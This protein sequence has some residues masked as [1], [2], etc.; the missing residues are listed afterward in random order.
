MTTDSIM[1]INRLGFAG[2]EMQDFAYLRALAYAD[3]AAASPG[4]VVHVA[5]KTARDGGGREAFIRAWTEQGR[6]AARMADDAWVA[7]RRLT[8]RTFLHRAYNYLRAAEFYCDRGRAEEFTAL[9]DRSV[10]CFDRALP[11]LDTPAERIAIPYE[12]GVALPGYFFAADDSGTRR[13]T[14]II[15]GGGDGHGEELYFLAGVPHALAR[16]LNVV[17]FHGPGQRGLLHHHPDQ[18]FRADSEVPFAAV[19][20]FVTDRSDVQ[21]DRIALYGLSFG[22]YLAPRAAAYDRRVAALVANAPITDFHAVILDAL[23]SAL[24]DPV[25]ADA[26]AEFWNGLHQQLGSADWALHATVENYML[27]TTG[28]RTLSDF[29]RIARDFTLDGL[30]P[31]ISCPTL[32]LSSDGENAVARRQAR[33]FHERLDVPTKAIHRLAAEHGADSHCG[34]SNIAL[35]SALVYDWLTD[36]LGR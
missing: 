1:A 27:W 6:I 10:S 3:H 36:V 29:L 15:S 32:T 31:R 26:P 17:L 23:T 14:V 24:P 12:N 7:G 19:L 2:S 30:V 20:D 34:L 21:A 5:R 4:E 16:G 33:E 13:P 8:A 18:V 35:T 28:A 9:Y 22:G 25:P 11:L